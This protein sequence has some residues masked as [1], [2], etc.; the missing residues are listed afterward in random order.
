L[1]GEVPMA[2][3]LAGLAIWGARQGRPPRPS[4]TR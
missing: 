2:L 1:L 3:L 4:S